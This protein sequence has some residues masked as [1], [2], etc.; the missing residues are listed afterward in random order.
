MKQEFD[1]NP[2]Y[3]DEK[4]DRN[5][6]FLENVWGE[7]RQDLIE[8]LSWN[9]EGTLAP[10]KF[11]MYLPSHAY[12]MA[13]TFKRPFKAELWPSPRVDPFWVHY[14]QP[15]ATSW[16]DFIQAN[17]EKGNQVLFPPVRRSSRINPIVDVG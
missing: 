15:V 16:E 11:W 8:A 17:L 3:S 1:K 7:A 9:T 12:L 10:T 4:F 13:D 6:P 2:L 14:V 5:Q